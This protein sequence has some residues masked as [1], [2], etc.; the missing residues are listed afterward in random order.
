MKIINISCWVVEDAHPKF[1]FRWR[2][3]LQ[4]SGDGTSLD[5]KPLKAIIRVDTDKNIYGS[6]ETNNALSAFSLVERRYKNF[7]GLNPLMSEDLWNKMWELDRI[8]EIPMYHFGL[9]DEM[10]WDIKSK[11]SRLPIYQLVGGKKK[12]IKAYAS[13]VTWE[14]MNEYEKHIKDCMNI[15]F[16][17]FKLHAWGDVKDDAKLSRNLRKWTG[18]DAS[19]MFDGSAGW[20]YVDSLN[21]GKI[22]QD[23]NFL[24]YEEPMREFELGSYTKLCEKLDIPILAAE[25]SDGCHWNMATW[26]QASALDMTRASTFYKGGITGAIKIAHLSESHGMRTQIHGMGFGN[27]QLCAAIPNNDF[28]EQLVISEKQI[29]DLEKNLHGSLAI[30]DGFLNVNDEPG[31]GYDYDWDWVEKNALNKI[32]LLDKK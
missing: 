1:P 19:L 20:D 6:I 16:T 32:V 30:K 15:G 26:I 7:I 9:L 3:G 11:Y 4:G 2:K 24:W 28:Y 22:I 8:E 12:K 27:A 25:T 18:E 13:T 5:K 10:V 14:T 23:E 31:L 21:F 29:L 17:A